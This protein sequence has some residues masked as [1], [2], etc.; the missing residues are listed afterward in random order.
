VSLDLWQWAIAAFGAAMVGLGK[1]G[2]AGMGVL[3]VAIFAT[4]LPARESVGILLVILISADFV[5]VA[6]YR[7]DA[8]WPHLWRLFPWVAAGVLIGA[9][10]FGVM[11]DAHVRVVI[12]VILVALVVVQLVRNRKEGLPLV[13]N[14]N[15][16]LVATTGLATGFTTM[17]ANAAGPLMILYLLAMRLPKFT[18]VGTAAWFFLALNLFKVPFSV[19]L[20]LITPSSLGF[21]LKL[22]PFAVLGALSGRWLITLMNQ[23]MFEGIALFLTLVAGVR[24]LIG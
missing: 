4:I 11:N 18:F 8:S 6:V 23:R 16:W 2:I 17:I 10:A 1:T 7:R 21:S 3:S 13:E 19:G 22:V 14:P 15:R 20:G 9:A 12:G 5:A 24:L